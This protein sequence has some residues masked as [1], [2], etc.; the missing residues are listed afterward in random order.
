[1]SCKLSSIF[2]CATFVLS[3]V[4]APA[5]SAQEAAAA[6][7][8]GKVDEALK[9][10]ISYVETL[11]DCGFPDFAEPVI[12]A[13]KKKWPESDALFFAIEIR[14]MLSLGKFAEAEA[15]IAALPDRDG[16]KY[17]AARLE[18]ANNYFQQ[19]KKKECAEIYGEFF[20]KF[21]S[22]PKGLRDFYLQACYAYGQLLIADKKFAEATERYEAF[23]KLLDRKHSDE[24]A[25]TWC[26]VACETSEMYLRMASDKATPGE[27]AR[28]LEGAKKLVD[29]LLWEQGRPVYFGRAIAMKANIEL[30]KGRTDRAQATIDDYMDQLAEL[31]KSIKDFDPDGRKGLLRQSPMPLCRYMLADMYWGEIAAE[32]KKPKRDDDRIKDLMF[33]AKG[34]NG[35]RNGAGAYNHAVNVY[36]QY[37]ESAWAAKAEKLMKRIEDLAIKQY[38]AKIK[39]QVTPAQAAKVR[40]M[41]FRNPN[42]KM[43]EGLYEEAIADY[44]T[45]LASYPEDKESITA[46][47]KVLQAY[48]RLIGAHPKDPKAEGWRLDAD[49]IQGYLAERFAGH[50]DKVLMSLAGDAVMREASAEKS[51]SPARADRLYKAFLRNYTRHVNAATTAAAMAG[52]A[53][54]AER[55]EDAIALWNVVDTT[56]TNSTF[57]TTALQNLA[58]CHEKLGERAKAIEAMKKYCAVETLPLKRTQA[59]M[60]LAIQYQKDG[61][62]ILAN[63]ETNEAPEA[64]EAQVKQGNAQII[65]GIKQFSDFAK[66]AE[67]ALGDPSVSPGEKKEY[68]K[69]REGALYLV[70]D[71]WGR[72]SKPEDRRAFFRGQAITNFENYVALYPR[73]KYA[74]SAY[75]KLGTMYSALGETERTRD[76]LARLAK[77]F[78]DADET[79]N[80]TPR[81]AKSLI[82]MGSV[83]EG[84]ELYA[85]MMRNRGANYSAGQYVN[86]GEALITA[87]SWDLANQAF[88]MAIEKAG[89]NSYYTV[90]KARIGMAKALYRQKALDAAQDALQAF[91]DDKKMSRMK[92]AAEAHELMVSV[93]SE[94]GSKQRDDKLRNKAFTTAIRSLKQLRIL[95]KDRPQEDQDRTVLMSGDVLIRRM[96]AEDEMNLEAQAQTTCAKAAGTLQAF[97]LEH[98]VSR[99][100]LSGEKPVV[101]ERT[102]EKDGQQVVE[103]AQFMT[104]AAR[105]NLAR[106]YETLIPLYVR[107]GGANLGFALK[108]GEEYLDLF[109]NG[110]GRAAVQNAINQAKTMGAALPADDAA[111]PT[112]GAEA[113]EPAETAEPAEAA[114]PAEP[115]AEAPVAESAAPAEDVK[116]ETA[117]EPAAEAKNESEGDNANE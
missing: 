72:L 76:A 27:R 37:P 4:A 14:G 44:L 16:G 85:E 66:T 33:G 73:G 83:K 69:L 77:E 21:P 56:Y 34:K 57:Y 38:K 20:K 106:C 7:D 84:T 47:E 45:A 67:K 11:I 81:L 86:A 32:L 115:A 92:I 42:E 62:E 8:E 103:P 22:P 31:H 113:A 101:P 93:A 13:T 88:E 97:L 36:I 15:K 9:A 1:M 94:L 52:E 35:K 74:K 23:L 53:Q 55:Y 108:Y 19:G 87:R 112:A 6:A 3:A 12:A 18:V 96:K 61:L 59:Q 70:G 58:L 99:E 117:A 110:K 30:L 39:T 102:V 90:A 2:G 54:K 65:R 107:L 116:E 111:A 25:N 105:D 80:S 89:T 114:E 41:Q 91:L 46:I 63:A 49:A 10:E 24:D 26:N 51:T 98:E 60:Q 40:E 75:V 43:A 29:Q 48:R 79:K 17:W 104:A 78:P 109:P 28:D 82:E 64:V 5:A 71:C 50:P 95:W 100:V 68:D